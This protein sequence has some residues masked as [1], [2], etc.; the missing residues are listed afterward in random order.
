MALAETGPA[1]QV[2][3]ESVAQPSPRF[4]ST[5][6]FLASLLQSSCHSPRCILRREGSV[7]PVL[8]QEIR[9]CFSRHSVGA[10]LFFAFSEMGSSHPFC[11]CH[12]ATSALW[13]TQMMRSRR[14][15]PTPPDQPNSVMG[16]P[17]NAKGNDKC[18]GLGLDNWS[19]TRP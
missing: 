14:R 10:R 13:A 2:P 6:W 16:H 7:R 19:E 15:V 11:G 4:C 3:P 5:V 18:A 8:R 12:L 17:Q 9:S 1:P